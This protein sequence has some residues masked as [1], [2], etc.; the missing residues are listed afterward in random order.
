MPV[1][2]TN[3]PVER[4]GRAAALDRP[5]WGSAGVASTARRIV[6]GPVRPR[7]SVTLPVSDL[8]PGAPE[9]TTSYEYTPSPAVTIAVCAVVYERLEAAADRR[10]IDRHAGDWAGRK[11][12]GCDGD[13]QQH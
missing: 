1:V 10:E 11:R 2:V 3:W 6:A 8:K 12:P 9:A 5:R 13:R 7:A 4:R